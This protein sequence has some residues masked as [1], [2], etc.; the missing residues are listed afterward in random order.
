MSKT[1]CPGSCHHGLFNLDEGADVQVMTS[2]FTVVKS[3]GA[4]GAVSLGSKEGFPKTS[5]PVPAPHKLP[6][7]SIIPPTSLLLPPH[8]PSPA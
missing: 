1:D 5:V 4:T 2:V 7:S 6:L 8:S 3:L